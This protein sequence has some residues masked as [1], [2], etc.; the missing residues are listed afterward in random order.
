MR[1]PWGTADHVEELF[2]GA[3]RVSTPSH[4]GIRLTAARNAEMPDALRVADGWY[5][6]DCEAALVIV[7]F[8]DHFPDRTVE[9]AKISV[10][11]WF[12]DRY[13][14]HFGVPVTAAESTVVAEEAFA[15]KHRDDY[16]TVAAWGSWHAGVPDGQV[17]VAA[18]VGGDRSGDKVHFLVPEAE[19]D[20]RVGRFVVDPDRHQRIDSEQF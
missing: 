9:S 13:S 10:R 12:P 19:Y 1:T 7:A 20:A 2:D 14:A 3:K 8:P 15:S 11:N 4:G 16:V 5:E 17:A 6:E 18:T